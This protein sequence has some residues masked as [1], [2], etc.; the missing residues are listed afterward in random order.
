MPF[1]TTVFGAVAPRGSDGIYIGPGGRMLFPTFDH[2]LVAAGTLGSGHPMAPDYDY[3]LHRRGLPTPH[4]QHK[5]IGNM[6]SEVGYALP[7]AT[8]YVETAISDRYLITDS[9]NGRTN[10]FTMAAVINR[11]G[12]IP[13]EIIGNLQ[14]SAISSQRIGVSTAGTLTLACDNA[15]ETSSSITLSS[16]GS[17]TSD[18]WEFVAGRVNGLSAK[19]FRRNAA[20]NVFVTSTG[21]LTLSALGWSG[22]AIRV[23]CTRQPTPTNVG[24]VK[25]AA[26]AVYDKSLSDDEVSTVYDR[27]KTYLASMSNPILI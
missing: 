25:I 26:W 4:G 15:S 7:D 9:G 16:S 1:T 8:N 21:T 19:L 3:A 2:A 12:L 17:T 24:G 11:T 5:I 22:N 18:Q 10:Q 20:Q 14:T 6:E 27:I 23:G 13:G